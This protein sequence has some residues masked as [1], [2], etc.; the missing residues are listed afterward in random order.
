MR[1]VTHI[2]RDDRASTAVEFAMV[3]PLLLLLLLGMVDAG[4]FMWEY[5]EAEKA[6]QM[7]ARYAVVTDLVP[8]TDFADF[9]FAID[10]GV[11]PG[12]PVPTSEF[13]YVSCDDAS[14]P[15]CVG[16]D[17]CGT[18][19]YDSDA[20][21]NIVSRMVAMYP[22]IQ[23][24]NVEVEYRNAGLGYAGDPNGP[25]VAPIVTVSLKDLQFQPITC[26]LFACSIDMPD[27]RAALTLEDGSGTVSN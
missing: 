21:G 25:D 4:R 26:F 27:F 9:S 20:F 13:D 2:I 12:D 23:P 22:L 16:G 10:A 11:T 3:L 6:T 18:V 15:T 8:G 24:A 17:V 1:Y 5:N 7:G 19:N 14:C